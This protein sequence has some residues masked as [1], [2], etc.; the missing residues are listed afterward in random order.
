MGGYV[1]CQIYPWPG[2]IHGISTQYIVSPQTQ[3]PW[4]VKLIFN[5]SDFSWIFQKNCQIPWYFPGENF[6]RYFSL[7]SM[8]VGTMMWHTDSLINQYASYSKYAAVCCTY[9]INLIA[10]LSIIRQHTFE[11]NKI[12]TLQKIFPNSF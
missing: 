9:W 6:V 8:I 12:M 5:L 7:F 2:D 1:Y 10:H 3:I 11:K 4:Y